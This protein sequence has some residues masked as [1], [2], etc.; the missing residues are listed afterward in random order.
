MRRFSSHELVSALYKGIL[1]RDADKEGL[2]AYV[3]QADRG[4]DLVELIKSFENSE[5]H[6]SKILAIPK[7]STVTLPNLK[8]LYPEKYVRGDSEN[9]VF[10]AAN[11]SEFRWLEEQIISNRYY[12]S[13]EVYS[14]KIDLDKTVTAALAIGLGG[15]SCLELGCFTGPVLSVL[16]DRGVDICGVDASHLAFVLAYPN[17]RSRLRFGDLLQQQFDQQ[18]D[19]FLAMDVLEHLDPVRMDSYVQK[20]KQI[21]NPH[22][23]AVVNSPMFGDDDIF[24]AVAPQYMPEWVA[25]GESDFWRHVHCDGQGWPIHGH[26]VNASPKWWESVFLRN[27]LVRDRHIERHIQ[28]LLADFYVMAPA[29]KTL[30]ILRRDDWTPDYPAIERALQTEIGALPIPK[31]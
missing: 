14:P 31:I 9:S 13:G 15:K 27:G 8:A 7:R 24:G 4:L 1:G 11:D 21:T 12:D 5:E 20:I 17:V 19:I 28:G 6:D 2:A 30:F 16:A 3:D 29:R 18:F 10:Y 22:G 25:A 23:F 26:L